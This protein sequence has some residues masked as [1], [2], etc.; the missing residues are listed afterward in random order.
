MAGLSPAAALVY[1]Q[2]A[3]ED[4]GHELGWAWGHGGTNYVEVII[5]G[6]RFVLRLTRDGDDRNDRWG[7][8][9]TLAGGRR[10]EDLDA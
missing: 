6:Q 2:D 8:A 7:H 9:Q 1:I 4:A 3:I 5:H 10:R